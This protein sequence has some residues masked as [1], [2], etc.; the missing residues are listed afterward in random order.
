V[1]GVLF[2]AEGLAGKQRELVRFAQRVNAF[3]G[4]G[5]TAACPT[6]AVVGRP[7]RYRQDNGTIR[8]QA[9]F[10]RDPPHGCAS[11]QPF[12][13]SR[14][15]VDALVAVMAAK[16]PIT[17]R[18]SKFALNKGADLPLLGAM[19]FEVPIQPFA[20]KPGRFATAGME[21]FA[22]ADTRAARRKVS[23]AFWQEQ[24]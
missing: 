17:V 2:R 13:R 24:K 10:R 8:F 12:A 22:Q 11:P 23:K 7:R 14:R 4:V 1:T 6:A 9:E 5:P 20:N 21:D 15:P 19:A 16:N 3:G 18:R